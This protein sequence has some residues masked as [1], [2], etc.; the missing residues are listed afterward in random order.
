MILTEIHPFMTT[1]DWGMKY[2]NISPQQKATLKPR[3]QIANL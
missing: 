2:S 3:L 1:Q